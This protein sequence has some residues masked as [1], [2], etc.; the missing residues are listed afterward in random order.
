MN[1]IDSVPVAAP[2][3]SAI[4]KAAVIAL[5]V[6]LLLLSAVVLPAE[7]G[8]DPVGTGKA[9]GLTVISEAGESTTPEPAAAPVVKGAYVEEA[10]I[11]KYDSQDF[12]LPP[13]DGMEMKYHMQKGASMVY[14][15]KADGVLEFEFHG[16][17]DQKP[18]KDYYD[19]YE[20]N[21]AGKD[22]SYGSFVAPSTGIHGWYFK[23]NSDK[24]IKFH[25]NVAGFIDG[26][27]MFAGGPGEDVPI[28]DAK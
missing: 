3:K 8:Y 21:K 2:S 23:N 27:K 9:L 26:A 18:S 14:A 17:P 10:R 22:A 24:E 4:A 19:S 28:E 6:A 7:Y 11:F 16:E 1:A 20:L 15:W 13:G 5:L 12:L 25:L